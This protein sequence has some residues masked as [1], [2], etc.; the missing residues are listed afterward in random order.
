MNSSLLLLFLYGQ[1][2]QGAEAN[3]SSPGLLL[4]ANALLAVV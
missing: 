4:D 2:V 1:D 3:G